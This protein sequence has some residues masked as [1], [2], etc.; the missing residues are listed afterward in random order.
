VSDPILATDAEREQALTLLRDASVDGRLTVEDLAERAELVHAARTREDLA[1]ATTG[2]ERAAAPPAGTVDRQRALLSSLTRDGRW[3]LA[4][5]TRFSA[6]LG[7]VTLDLREA[8]LPG[9]DVE[10]EARAILGSVT[11]IVPA[12][13][14][15]D[16]AGTGVLSSA[17]VRVDGTPPAGAP[18][19]RIR[20]SGLM[21][22]LSVRSRR[23]IAKE[24]KAQLKRYL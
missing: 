19:V 20:H 5:R 12:G 8:V 23:P 24:I 10:I 22:S 21:G 6:V 2:L 16:V 11:V 15:V 7:S 9:P 14:E 18:L 3:R 13:V 1:A 4:P 17:D